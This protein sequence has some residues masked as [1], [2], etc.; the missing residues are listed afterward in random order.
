MDRMMDEWMGGEWM[1]GWMNG[2]IGGW[3]FI[4]GGWVDGWKEYT[5]MDEFGVWMERW[6]NVVGTLD[7]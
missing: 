5:R 6:V 3:G 7:R 4:V 2:W 1:N